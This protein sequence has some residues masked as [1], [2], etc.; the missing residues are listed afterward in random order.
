MK[1]SI[2]SFYSDKKKFTINNLNFTKPTEDCPKP[3]NGLWLAKSKDWYDWCKKESY[4]LKNIKHQYKVKVDMTDIYLLTLDNFQNFFK[5]YKKFSYY[6]NWKKFVK[7]NPTCKGIYITFNY[8]DIMYSN[9][10]KLP[11]GKLLTP[12]P[13]SKKKLMHKLDIIEPGERAILD[14]ELF[15]FCWDIPSLCVWD[16]SAVLDFKLIKNKI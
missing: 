16:K 4:N 12:T 15:I 1:T 13:E 10:I 2:F 3:I 9:T 8:N 6:I 11:L 14:V 7:N 5:L